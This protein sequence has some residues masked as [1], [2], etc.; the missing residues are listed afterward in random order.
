MSLARLFMRRIPNA[1]RAL[2]S[3]VL[4]LANAPRARAQCDYIWKAENFPA[5]LPGVQ[6]FLSTSVEWDPDGAGTLGPWLV[7]GGNFSAAGATTAQNVAGWD[8]QS[9]HD[10]SLPSVPIAL[11]VWNGQLIALANPINVYRRTGNTWEALPAPPYVSVP[12]ADVRRLIEF[13]GQGYA[14]GRFRFE[15]DSGRIYSRVTRWD[16]EHW[17]PV[18]PQLTAPTAAEDALVFQDRLWVQFDAWDGESWT[19]HAPDSLVRFKHLLEHEQQLYAVGWFNHPGYESGTSLIHWDGADWQRVESRKEVWQAISSGNQIYGIAPDGV[20]VFDNQGWTK[21]PDSSAQ[22]MRLGDYGGRLF[23]LGSFGVPA[24]PPDV[25]GIKWLSGTSWEYL[26]YQRSLNGQ[27]LGLA[28]VGDS[29]FATGE[30]TE[31]GGVAAQ[32]AA[33]WDGSSWHALENGLS[34]Q[35]TRIFEYRGHAVF[36]QTNILS[37]WDETL[38]T[39]IPKQTPLVTPLSNQRIVVLNDELI[40]FDSS[41]SQLETYRWDGE[42]WQLHTGLRLPQ[43]F[44][45]TLLTTFQSDPVALGVSGLGER[46]Y[47]TRGSRFHETWVPF[48]DNLAVE[49]YFYPGGARYSEINFARTIG[50]RTFAARV[51]HESYRGDYFND[52]KLF[53]ANAAGWSLMG[54]IGGSDTL[55]YAPEI[56][57]FNGKPIVSSHY[58]GWGTGQDRQ[59]IRHLAVW[60]NTQFVEIDGGLSTAAATLAVYRNELWVGGAFSRAGNLVSP[61]LAR[62]GCPVGCECDG[63]HDGVFDSVDQCPGSDDRIDSDGDGISDCLDNCPLTHNPDQTDSDRDGRGDA[64]IT[65][66]GDDSNGIGNDAA[67]LPTFNCGACGTSSQLTLALLAPGLLGTI[68]FRRYRSR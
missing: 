43:D 26:P 6:G 51:D 65:S 35:G 57:V 27:V 54:S 49:S 21:L 1:T 55:P 62:W 32:Y 12:W 3:A 24:A 9:W 33:R 59:T 36:D 58:T 7:V 18:G 42:A 17:Q 5:S 37:V 28:V 25:G 47:F 52:T 19:S 2:L 14:I 13:R 63:D 8:G 67:E 38:W 50:V 60:N 23:A 30:F 48:E 45:T 64:C 4:F 16:G 31:I 39:S 44:T 11:S 15:S 66:G 10:L 20:Y 41:G 68:L 29:L 53:E 61:Y 46:S 56:A 34:E 40:A 22:I